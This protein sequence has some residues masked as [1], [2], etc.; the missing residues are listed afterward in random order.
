[1][2]V[3]EIGI[4]QRE[5]NV[6]YAYYRTVI[7]GEPIILRRI[8]E[9]DRRHGYELLDKLE[10][11]RAINM[12]EERIYENIHKKSGTEDELP[13]VMQEGKEIDLCLSNIVIR[14][15]EDNKDQDVYKC[16]IEEKYKKLVDDRREE[17]KILMENNPGWF[18]IENYIEKYEETIGNKLSEEQRKAI[19]NFDQKFKKGIVVGKYSLRDYIT[20]I[21]SLPQL[22]SGKKAIG[23]GKF[24]TTKFAPT[25][26]M[27]KEPSMKE[28][29]RYSLSPRSLCFDYIKPFFNNLREPKTP[30]IE[31]RINIQHHKIV[32]RDIQETFIPENTFT[33]EG[34]PQLRLVGTG[35][36]SCDYVVTDESGIGRLGPY[37]LRRIKKLIHSANEIGEGVSEITKTDEKK[38]LEAFTSGS[39]LEIES[40]NSKEEK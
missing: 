35:E 22:L 31:Y 25:V 7:N 39:N 26:D 29:A 9:I 34:Y 18:D 27:D 36:N 13:F 19:I 16:L 12:S 23:I 20:F 28:V 8:I 30:S 4:Y 1:M 10:Y 33:I 32:I 38:V 2:K 15:K 11:Y 40:E 5:I 3:T 24:F 14:P 17:L 21:N 37:R 6:Y